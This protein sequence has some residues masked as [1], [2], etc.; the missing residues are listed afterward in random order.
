[1]NLKPLVISNNTF[2]SITNNGKTLEAIFSMFP[3]H[4]LS[5][6]YFTDYLKPDLTYCSRYFKM[7]DVDVLKNIFINHGFNNES[8]AFENE[9]TINS[10]LFVKKNNK[11]FHLLRDIL[12]SIDSWKS[13]DLFE[14]IDVIN[15]DF[16][17]FVAGGNSFSH[18]VALFLSEKFNLPLL[19][20]FT[21]DYVLYE[22]VNSF[23]DRILH[24]RKV[25]YYRKLI[26]SSSLCFAI[27]DY[28]AF[29]YEAFFNKKFY[30]L[31]NT[32]DI[33]HEYE[34]KKVNNSIVISYF[35]SLHT[36]RDLMLLKFSEILA[37]L[38]SFVVQINV[39]TNT[40]PD[41]SLLKQFQMNSIF[42]KGNLIG[43]E[44]ILAM[45]SSDFLLHIESDDLESVSKT[46]LSVSTKIP[47]YLASCKPIISFGPVFVASLK[48]QIDNEIGFVLDSENS[49]LYNSELLRRIFLSE[50]LQKNISFKGFNY[51]K[52]KFSR[53]LQNQLF[54]SNLYKLFSK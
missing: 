29:E 13:N 31:I 27:C 52:L 33:I 16:I 42:Y 36:N 20:Y 11:L 1:M 25:Y 12:W 49:V 10:N 37:T 30:T 3:K 15:P 28:M 40:E 19:T 44:L 21:D 8:Y 41:S 50:D 26:S 6:I 39:Y 46:R 34:F 48:I 47:E 17:F 45:K 9:N 43:D 7:T 51:A 35:G 5:Q 2:S 18:R 22:S 23:F 4:N 24:K 38:G 54:K 53:A 14:W 32:V